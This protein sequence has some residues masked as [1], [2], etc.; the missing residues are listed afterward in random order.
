MWREEK[1]E[2]REKLIESTKTALVYL[3]VWSGLMIPVIKM[4]L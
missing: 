4:F 3:A 2:L 1:Q